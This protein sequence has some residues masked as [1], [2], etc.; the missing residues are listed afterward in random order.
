VQISKRLGHASPAI[1]LAVYS[2][3]FRKDDTAVSAAINA[4]VAKLGK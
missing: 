3:F 4:A 1:T 2:H